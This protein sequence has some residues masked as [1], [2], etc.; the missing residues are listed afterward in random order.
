[1][2]SI[3]RKTVWLTLLLM[4]LLYLFPSP[5]MA[6]AKASGDTISTNDIEFTPIPVIADSILSGR[7]LLHS[8]TNKKAITA[9][10]PSTARQQTYW[11]IF[12]AGFFGGLAALLMPCIFPMLPLTVSFFTKKGGSKTRSVSQA[13]IYGLSIITIY[14]LLG[15]LI[16]LIFGSDALNALSTNGIFNFFFFLLLIVFGISFL[17]A[18]EITLPASLGNR[19]HENSEKGGYAGLFF[20]GSNAGGGII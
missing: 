2:R 1:M 10:I 12:I 4:G 13:G 18:F 6:Q 14:V 11:Q 7:N 3:I 16:T 8:E 17:G 5:V 20:Y 9:T 19:L 15:L